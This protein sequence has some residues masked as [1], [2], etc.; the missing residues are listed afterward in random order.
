MFRAE[1]SRRVAHGL[2]GASTARCS[3]WW[4]KVGM[5]RASTV[6]AIEALMALTYAEEQGG[7]AR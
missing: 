6:D 5:R 4:R 2:S 1:R 7:D 3:A